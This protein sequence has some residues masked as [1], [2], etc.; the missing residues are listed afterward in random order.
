MREDCMKKKYNTDEMSEVEL[1]AMR[2]IDAMSDEDIDTS[3]IPEQTAWTGSVRG[4]FYDPQARSVT[5]KPRENL[6]SQSRR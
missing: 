5:R 3:D 4:K 2:Q 6:T 1:E